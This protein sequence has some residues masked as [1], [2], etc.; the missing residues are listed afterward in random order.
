V[1][2]RI[3]DDAGREVPAG[4][5]G[6]VWF[7]ADFSYHADPA[8]TAA[9]RHGAFATVGDVG[10]L[11]ADGYLF[12]LDR[13]TDLIITGGVNVYPAEIEAQLAAHPQ[14]RDVAVV[15]VPDEQWGHRVHA[16]VERAE[17]DADARLEA[18]LR[19]L[20]EQTLAGPKRPRSYEF[21]D[22]LPRTE[23]GKLSRAALRAPYWERTQV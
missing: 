9:A 10:C 5:A 4:E 15:A 6:T 12:L 19:A 3:L 1:T 13:R 8:K 21:R 2:V 17:T 16:I 18:E 20:C 23:S 14:V 11:D 7:T 22:A